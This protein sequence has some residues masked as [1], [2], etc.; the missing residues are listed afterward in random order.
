MSNVIV[1]L[2]QIKNPNYF[3]MCMCCKEIQKLMHTPEQFGI[4]DLFI[5]QNKQNM[6]VYTHIGLVNITQNKTIGDLSVAINEPMCVNQP[7]ISNMYVQEPRRYEVV[8]ISRIQ[9][10]YYIPKIENLLLW[11]R[12][13]V[14][15]NKIMFSFNQVYNP[16]K[17]LQFV[18]LTEYNQVYNPISKIWEAKGSNGNA[19]E[20][21]F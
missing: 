4:G 19:Q 2:Y 1:H 6:F 18:M 12:H 10:L 5:D 8:P 17:L 13:S 15:K 20:V 3:D 21:P 9:S 7:D 16:E 11:V 14:D